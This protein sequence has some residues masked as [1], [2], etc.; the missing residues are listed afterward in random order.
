MDRSN[1]PSSI[2][3]GASIPQPSVNVN[4]N[5]VEA[6]LPTGES[7]SVHLYGATV[8]SW[9]LASG[10]EQLFVSSKAILDGSKPIRGGIP[11]VFPVSLFF[12]S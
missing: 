10:E 3:V 11:V 1:K 6:T 7:V 2:G 5:K 8:T 4:E 9:K 12:F